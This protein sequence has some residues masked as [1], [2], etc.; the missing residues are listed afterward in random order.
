M[1]VGQIGLDAVVNGGQRAAMATP[2]SPTP[3]TEACLSI[4][5]TGRRMGGRHG[6]S[7]H[8]YVSCVDD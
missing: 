8:V 4:Q 1:Q 6:L 2:V 5:A 7:S 3:P